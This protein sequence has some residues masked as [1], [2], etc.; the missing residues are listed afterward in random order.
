MKNFDNYDAFEE[1]PYSGQEILGSRY[2]LTQK[3]SGVVKARFVVKGFQE[4]CKAQSDSP[5]ASRETLKI[6]LAIVANE[7]WSL[8]SNDVKS[9]FLQSHKI[10]R[11]IFVKPPPEREK[12]GIV[13]KLKKPVYGLVDASR[14]WFLTVK[15][16][17][18]SV[19]MKQ[20]LGDSCLFAYRIK[21]KLEGLMIFHVDDFLAAGG[22]LFERNII[23]PLMQQFCFGKRS[24]GS[25]TYTGISIQQ[26][27]N[28]TIAIDQN[29]F[30]QSLPNYEYRRQD[31][32]SILEKDENNK[33]RK[34]AGQ[35][36]WVSSQTRPDLPFDAFKLSTCLGK[37]THKDAKYSSKVILKS[38]Y[39]NV[40]LNFSHLGNWKKLHLELYVDAALGNV[41]E[42]QKTKSMMGYIILLCDDNGNFSPIHWKSKIIDRVAPDVKTAETIALETALDDAIFISK[43]IS[44]IYTGDV[45][46]S[47]IPIAINEDSKSLVES[48]LSTKKVKR[49]SMRLAI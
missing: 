22:D 21:G 19:G 34:T 9:A 17:L 23:Q 12:D 25:F 3:D 29:E 31:P 45:N 5:T 38:K 42:D 4:G 40:S 10:D 33:I 13:W 1:V 18:E 28:K 2:V 14:K 41:E 32:E 35:L 49:K 16:F 15:H 37:A 47:N 43:I 8:R 36:N 46:E 24:E 44:E 6:F 11:D 27:E 48:L 30:V 39:E 7:K 20:S 26:D